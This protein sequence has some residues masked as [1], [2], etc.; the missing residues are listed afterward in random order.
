[1]GLTGRAQRRERRKR[2]GSLDQP[3]ELSSFDRHRLDRAGFFQILDRL[4]S[5]RLFHRPQ[6]CPLYQRSVRH[7]SGLRPCMFADRLYDAL[8]PLLK[9]AVG[10]SVAA[11]RLEEPR[12]VIGDLTR[13]LD[14]RRVD[15][16]VFDATAR[17]VDQSQSAR[18]LA[19]ACPERLPLVRVVSDLVPVL[20]AF[21]QHPP[22]FGGVLDDLRFGIDRREVAAARVELPPLARMSHD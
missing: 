2:R 22:S 13:P 5:L 14:C 18:L 12:R 17:G 16:K 3:V 6:R 7:Q 11:L 10:D 4:G 9:L 19:C 15:A 1:M 21:K 20:S 8:M